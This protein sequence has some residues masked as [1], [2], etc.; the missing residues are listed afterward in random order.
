[1]S[2]IVLAAVAALAYVTLV[3]LRRPP[4]PRARRGPDGRH[5]DLLEVEVL[6]Q[7]RRAE[8]DNAHHRVGRP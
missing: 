2:P 5:L 4:A 3:L 7:I 8:R 6:D 1:M